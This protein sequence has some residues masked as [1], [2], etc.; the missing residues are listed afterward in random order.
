[1]LKTLQAVADQMIESQ[2]KS[3]AISR[4][5]RKREISVTWRWWSRLRVAAG[6]TDVRVC[7]GKGVGSGSPMPAV[8]V[9]IAMPN[10]AAITHELSFCN[11]RALELEG[12]AHTRSLPLCWGPSG[13]QSALK[14]G[15][16]TT[17]SSKSFPRPKPESDLRESP[18]GLALATS[19][20]AYVS[21]RQTIATLFSCKGNCSFGVFAA[22]SP[23]VWSRSSSR[24]RCRF[25][26]PVTNAEYNVPVRGYDCIL[27]VTSLS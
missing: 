23:E 22:G 13:I 21:S 9:S 18:S 5:A 11:K 16:V 3:D 27:T 25:L 24:Y 26:A 20:F 7:D 1:M 17:G 8:D 14:S 10:A 6:R 12:V 2:C 4:E 15:D 19:A